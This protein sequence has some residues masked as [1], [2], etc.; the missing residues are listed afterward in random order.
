[1]SKKT[2]TAVALTKNVPDLLETLNSEIAK[3]KHIEESVYKTSGKLSGAQPLD[4]KVEMKVENLI[5]AFSSVRGRENA[6]NDAARELGLTTYPQFTVDGGT[7]ADWKQ[8]ILLRKAIIEHKETLDK[9][10]DFKAKAAK[11]LSEEDQKSMLL[12][13]MAEYFKK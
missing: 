11:F 9:L 1:M 5:R 3:L 7:A 6:Y 4:I 2:T 12:A 13:E 8:D 10:N